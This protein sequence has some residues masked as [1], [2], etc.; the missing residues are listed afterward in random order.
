MKGYTAFVKKEWIES[1]RTY[2]F[3][4]L[5]MVFLLL[6]C[7]SPI[8][9][10]YMPEIIH[11]FMPSGMEM[12]LADPVAADAWLQFFKN[13]SQIGFFVTVILYSTVMSNEYTRGTLIPVLAK[14]L[15]R[16]YVILAKF[17]CACLSVTALYLICAGICAAYTWFFWGEAVY[18]EGV[19]AALLGMWLFSVLLLSLVM[20]GSVLFHSSYG[21]L[22]F[23]GGAVVIQMI[24][25]MVP[26]AVKFLPVGLIT[27]ST[28][29]LNG[30]I[31][32]ET[33]A[34]QMGI[35]VLMSLLLLTA[36]V[37]VFDRKKL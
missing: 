11:A 17:T 24:A 29:I 4:I 36:S 15:P 8:S 32:T 18:I 6:A 33:T 20:L 12:K 26:K 30:H 35:T 13:F 21:C 9:A 19:F 3:L 34:W 27:D 31:Q 7:L 16:K 1:I 14:G 37:L 5:G 25:G 28:E 22:L 10:R 2:R 23:T